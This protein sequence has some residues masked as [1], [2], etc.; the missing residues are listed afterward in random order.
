MM[1][2]LKQTRVDFNLFTHSN[3]MVERTNSCEL[4][5]RWW[6]L[7][8]PLDFL[9]VRTNDVRTNWRENELMWEWTEVRMYW[10]AAWRSSVNSRTAVLSGCYE[11]H[12]RNESKI[13]LTIIKTL[14]RYK[15]YHGPYYKCL[16]WQVPD[17]I[18][19]NGLKHIRLSLF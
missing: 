1:G 11:T 18:W 15:C 14:D 6:A 7:G 17:S 13:I 3:F 2:F 9:I 5:P 8:I 19:Q 12:P 16:K 4:F 10:S